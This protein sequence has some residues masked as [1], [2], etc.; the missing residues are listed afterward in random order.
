M[1]FKIQNAALRKRAAAID[2][3]IHDDTIRNMAAGGSTKRQIARKLRVS[4]SAVYG[5][6]RRNKIDTK[7][8]KQGVRPRLK[9]EEKEDKDLPS[10][11]D[12][13]NLVNKDK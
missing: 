10:T 5:Y 3:S 9:Q 7:Q 13:F 4:Y 8:S 6:C 12:P 2:W 11:F 1:K